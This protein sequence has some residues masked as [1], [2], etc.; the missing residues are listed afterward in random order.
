MNRNFYYALGRPFSPFYSTAMR[1]REYLYQKRIFKSTPFTVP[2]ISVGNLTLGGT[3]KTPM[4]Q[5]LARLL[6]ENGYQPAI[7]S[8]GYGGATKER[9]NIV[10]DGKEIFL[11]ADYVGDEPRMLAETLPGV[12]VLTGIVRKLPAA[13][14]VKMGADILLLDDG[15]QHMA[16]RRDLDIVLF[17]TDKLAGNSRV[18]PGGDLREPINALKR[19]HA[20]VLTGT[21]EQNQQRAENFKAVL[22]KKF[23]DKPVFFSRNCP[24]GLIL[25]KTDGEKIPVQPEELADQQCFAFCGIARPEGFNQTLNKLNIQP[26]ALR[27]LPDHFAYAAKTVRQLIAEAQQ[28]GATC[29]LCT[30]KDLV[31][32]RNI[33]LKL[34]LYGVVMEAQPD[35]ELNHL[36][37]QHKPFRST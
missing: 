20:F 29:F 10:S 16:I 23:P 34:P 14:A 8:R 27:A 3:G 33:D 35:K 26:I 28:A 4:V 31:K 19:C 32:L 5:Y 12:F 24:T 2:V 15:F 7:I 30:E 6:Q 25:Q 9:I 37:L 17:N 11:G 22:N 18:F 1:L 36:I 21:D 13:E